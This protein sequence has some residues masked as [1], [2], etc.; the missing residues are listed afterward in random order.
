M[1]MQVVDM[2]R[3]IVITATADMSL[4]QAQHRMQ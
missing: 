3:K 1:E 2:M 4:A